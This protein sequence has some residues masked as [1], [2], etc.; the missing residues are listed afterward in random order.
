MLKQ[1]NRNNLAGVSAADL[2]IISKAAK[3]AEQAE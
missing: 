1:V 3:V 2:A